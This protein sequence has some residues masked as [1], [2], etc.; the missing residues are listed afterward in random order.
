M[1][2]RYPKIIPPL[3]VVR[4]RKL[5]PWA[6]SKGHSVGQRYRVGYYGA[7][8]DWSYDEIWLVDDEGDYCWPVYRD[9]LLKHFEIEKL[10]N[11]TRLYG[12]GRPR[13]GPIRV[14]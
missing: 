10:S 6:R 12:R 13:I 1:K 7:C 8:R 3:T 4:L 11:E 5:F 2:K 9:F 14:G